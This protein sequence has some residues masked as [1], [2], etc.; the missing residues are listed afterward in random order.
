MFPQIP[1]NRPWNYDN[2][3]AGW[4]AAHCF[5]TQCGSYWWPRRKG[6][7]ITH[8]RVVLGSKRVLSRRDYNGQA[9][10]RRVID[11]PKDIQ[12][13]DSLAERFREDVDRKRDPPKRPVSDGKRPAALSVPIDLEGVVDSMEREDLNAEAPTPMSSEITLHLDAKIQKPKYLKDGVEDSAAPPKHEQDSTDTPELTPNHSTVSVEDGAPLRN[14][15]KKMTSVQPALTTQGHLEL[16][17]ELESISRTI[18]VL[19]TGSIGKFFAHSLAGLSNPP[20]VTL[21]IHRPLLIQQ[22]H[23]EGGAIS[24][25]IN[26]NAITQSG[27]NI[28]CSADFDMDAAHE[29]VPGFR[30]TLKHSAG[31][32]GNVIENLIVTTEGYTTVS[33]L[34]AIKHRLRASS[35]ICFVQDGLGVVDEV[36]SIVF[37]DPSR[38]PTYFL[39]NISHS[40]E[41]TEKTFTVVQKRTGAVSFMI[42]PREPSPA[43]DVVRPRNDLPLVRKMDY[44]WTPRARYLMRTL[45]RSPELK[46]VGLNRQDFL[47]TQLEK[48]A[49]NAV[50]GPVSVVFDCPNNYLLYNYQVSRTMKPLLKEI[51]HI[52]R[53]L[54]EVSRVSK[55]EDYFSAE[56]LE[57]LVVSV[58]AKTGKNLSSMLQAVR[59]G[60]KTDIDFYNGY[61]INRATELGIDCPRNEMLV[62]MVKGKQAMKSRELNSYI[63]FGKED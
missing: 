33:A 16:S 41:S 40:F 21:L 39:A 58:L 63:P 26:G 2:I 56:R 5:S 37:P 6:G 31:P 13:V 55:I 42:L 29:Q 30:R 32:P 9:A 62:S 18:H 28:E 3:H 23:D 12:Y 15:D 52:L 51:S 53:S 35:T 36:N 47:K 27:L 11:A 57:R 44:S 46:A 4:V 54:P 59:I 17:S 19:G 48:L 43:T 22:Y 34:S 20:S 10:E 24:L 50:V 49:I 38:R 61:L 1:R 14:A 25:L 8:L 60:Q 45:S 7:D